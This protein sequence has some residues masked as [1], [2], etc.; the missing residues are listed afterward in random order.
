MQINKSQRDNCIEHVRLQ[1]SELVCRQTGRLHATSTYL[2]GFGISRSVD[3]PIRSFPHSIEFFE[4][5]DGTATS[6]AMIRWNLKW[7]SR[8]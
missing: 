2:V 4:I 5:G 8:S 7:L 6:I 1:T 3:D